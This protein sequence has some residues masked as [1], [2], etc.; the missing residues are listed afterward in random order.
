MDNGVYVTGYGSL[1]SRGLESRAK[2]PDL[3]ELVD[4]DLVKNIATAHGKTPAQGTYQST[5][6][7]F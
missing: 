3:P 2:R 1:G 4:S 6:L 7:F 5:L